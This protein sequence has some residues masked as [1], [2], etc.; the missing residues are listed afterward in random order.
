MSKSASPAFCL[1][2]YFYLY[3]FGLFVLCYHH[4]A[5]AFSGLDGL[6]FVAEID[7]YHTYFSTIVS[8]DGTR[9]VEYG[10]SSFECQSAA[11]A[12]LG[13][14]ANGQFYIGL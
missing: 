14:V 2:Q 7:E 6:W 3:E 13:F 9:G 1:T 4:L 10:Q 5:Y 11:G 12:Y 8:I